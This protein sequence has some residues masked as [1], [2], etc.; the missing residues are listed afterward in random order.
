MTAVWSGFLVEPMVFG[1]LSCKT[2]ELNPLKWIFNRHLHT[3]QI[4]EHIWRFVHA[5]IVRTSTTDRQR[6]ARC[7]MLAGLEMIARKTL[8]VFCL[9][10]ACVSLQRVWYIAVYGLLAQQMCGMYPE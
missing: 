4:V 7:L 1:V 3:A 10:I 2:H 5:D 6:P 8:A 9:R